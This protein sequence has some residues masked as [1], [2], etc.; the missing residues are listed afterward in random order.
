MYN[1]YTYFT[2]NLIFCHDMIML[3]ELGRLWN[4]FLKLLLDK[5]AHFFVIFYF[6]ILAGKGK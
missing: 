3:I 5:V 2:T 6:R 1:E 4:I